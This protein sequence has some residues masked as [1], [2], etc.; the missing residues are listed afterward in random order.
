MQGIAARIDGHDPMTDV[1]HHDFTDPRLDGQKGQ[2]PNK[3]ESRGAEVRQA[4]SQFVQ[5]RLTGDNSYRS[6][7]VFQ[8]CR[9]HSRRATASGSVRTS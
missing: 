4:S 6:A 8:N 3:I 5:D 7:A 1:R 9:V 2:F